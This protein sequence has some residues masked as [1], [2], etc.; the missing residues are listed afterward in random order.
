MRLDLSFKKD[1]HSELIGRLESPH[2]SFP[3]LFALEPASGRANVCWSAGSWFRMRQSAGGHQVRFGLRSSLEPQT[4]QPKRCLA[5]G[6]GRHHHR[7]QETTGCGWPSTRRRCARRDRPDPPQ[8]PGGHALADA[9]LLKKK[10]VAPKR[11]TTD[12]LRA[13]GAARRQAMPDVEHRSHKGLNSRA[14]NAHVPL[15]KR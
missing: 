15:R 4:A 8:H 1:V 10:S 13:Y 9:P 5:P 12:K 2:F 6:R 7:R 11:M 3:G 14:E